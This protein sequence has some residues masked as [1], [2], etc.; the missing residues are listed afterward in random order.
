MAIP[1][2][3]CIAIITPFPYLFSSIQEAGQLLIGTHDFSAFS[4]AGTEVENKVRTIYHLD[5]QQAG[6]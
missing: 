3:G 2:E 5:C 1:F 4:S 6:G